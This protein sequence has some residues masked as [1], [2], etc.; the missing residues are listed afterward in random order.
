MMLPPAAEQPNDLLSPGVIGLKRS[1]ALDRIVTPHGDAGVA[2]PFCPSFEASKRLAAN[3][4]ARI[5]AAPPP[6]C[7]YGGKEFGSPAFNMIEK[8]SRE[9]A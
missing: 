9:R 6:D 2:A 5:L 4:A 1:D 3:E 8:T 7:Q